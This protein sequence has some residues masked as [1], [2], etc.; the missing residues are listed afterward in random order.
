MG[1]LS[2]EVED[3]GSSCAVIAPGFGK[4]FAKV[5]VAV[6]QQVG[7]PAL[8]VV[9]A[10][11]GVLF[12][13]R[14]SQSVVTVESYQIVGIPAAGFD[15]SAAHHVAAAQG[16]PVVG[17]VVEIGAAYFLHQ[18]GGEPFIGI[19][20]QHP[21]VFHVLQRYVLLY[22]VAEIGLAVD[23]CAGFGGHLDGPVGAQRV[24]HH[25]LVAH[26]QQRL[27]GTANVFLLVKG[28]YDTRYLL[29]NKFAHDVIRSV[30]TLQIYTFYSYWQNVNQRDMKKT[31]YVSE[32]VVLL[33]FKKIEKTMKKSTIVIVLAALAVIL[34]WGVSVN[35]RL[36]TE[37][38]NVQ[39][40]WSQV[41]NVYRRRMDLIPQLVNTVKGAADF[42]RKTLTE[43]INA[44]ANADKV[45]VDP[46]NLNEE[47]IAAFQKAQDQLSKAVANTIKVTVERYPE[48]TATQGF[49][50]LQT[51]LEGTENR[52]AVERGKFNEA[53]QTYNTKLRRF[54]NNII[55][56]IC[57]FDKKGYFTAPAEAAEP[58]QVEFDF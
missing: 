48:L 6:V 52:I 58:V 25:H 18:F 20:A 37:E 35:N 7:M 47:N 55:A 31:C 28:G 30:S 38:E 49:R 44:R 14:E 10:N 40:A 51:Q 22:A 50:D 56:G 15:P 2:F 4:K 1:S 16:K 41:E 26:L 13:F 17:R 33:H 29:L 8:C 53:V 45:T 34:L 36:V 12:H 39:K 43:V 46:S 3:F 5:V 23:T 19:D 27:D 21:K 11:G 54:P 24:D 57:G 32:K 9:G 42:E